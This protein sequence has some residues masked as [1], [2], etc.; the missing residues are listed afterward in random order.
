MEIPKQ[1][2]KSLTLSETSLMTE[3]LLNNLNRDE[4]IDLFAFMEKGASPD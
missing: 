4:I 1:D 3:G 2:I